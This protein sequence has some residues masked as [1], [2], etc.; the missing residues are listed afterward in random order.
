MNPITSITELVARANKALVTRLL[1]VGLPRY[2]KRLLF[3]VSLFAGLKHLSQTELGDLERLNEK[4][5]LSSSVEALEIPVHFAE[6]IWRNCDLDK[7]ASCGSL[8]A[9]ADQVVN[10]MP[11]WMQYGDTAKMV[12]D[13]RMVIQAARLG[14]A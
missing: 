11:S 7:A 6:R 8:K 10:A 4:M 5:G 13:A 2:G 14:L 1:R 3:V 12:D 9:G